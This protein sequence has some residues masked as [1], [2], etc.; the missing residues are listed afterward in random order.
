[1]TTGIVS[2]EAVALISPE[3][4]IGLSPDETF[5]VDIIID[6]DGEQ[7]RAAHV[8]IDYDPGVF[9]VVGITKGSIFDTD[10]LLEPG[11]GDDGAGTINYG[12]AF[13]SGISILQPMQMSGIEFQVKDTVE[14]GMHSIRFTEVELIDT[15][16]DELSGKATGSI[17]VIGDVE[18]AAMTEP[19][20]LDFGKSSE[21]MSSLSS[22]SLPSEAQFEYSYLFGSIPDDYK[23]LSR[24]GQVQ[25]GEDWSQD[26]LVLESRIMNEFEGE[27]L[28]WQGKIMSLG[29]N[30]AG[31]LVVVFYEPLM[32]ESSEVENIYEMIDEEAKDAGIE[33]VPVEFGE[34]TTTAISADLQELLMRVQEM[35]NEG[36]EN[37]TNDQSSL[38]DPM[39][40]G[41]VG[42]IPDIRTEKECWQWYYQDSYDISLNINDEMDSYLQGGV[43]L[44]T[45]LSPDGYFEI[46]INQAAD[47]D[48]EPL[49]DEIYAIINRE[50]SNIGITD[51]PV[52]F[53][54]ATPDETDSLTSTSEEVVEE[55]EDAGIQTQEVPGFNS[56][57]FLL[58]ISMVCYMAIRFQ[59]RNS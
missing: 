25:N 15:D 51:V 32:V 58:S 10:I 52:V 3:S 48:R 43:L 49:M 45:G 11:S 7:L 17:I 12:F 13:G 59:K 4:Q 37:L 23:V 24:R 18:G 5:F 19:D 6:S 42:D 28:F 55:M 46:N 26:I 40:I 22:S 30:S 57:M 36:I 50:A 1:M 44:S 20:T 35:E 39:V 27:Y 54:L 29:T 47:I 38:Y 9:E 31:Y 14:N 2:A 34:G 21:S 41:T 53:K 56:T 33:N 16:L 8:Q